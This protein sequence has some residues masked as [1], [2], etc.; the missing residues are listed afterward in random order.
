MKQAE[1]VARRISSQW[2]PAAI[3]TSPLS[4]AM[5]TAEIIGKKFHL[6]PIWTG[7]L[8][9][10]D[11]GQWQGLTPA[12][13]REKWPE[14]VVNWYEHPEV[15]KIPGGETLMDVRN[16]AMSALK[17]ACWLHPDQEIVLVSHTVV[18]RLILLGVLGL[19]IERFWH[20][21]QDPCAMNIIEKIDDDF[22][23]IS[24]NDV[25]HIH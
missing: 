11:Y 7:E 8:S 6:S 15:A 10:I 18:N 5:Q 24:M 4:R 12:E 2:K 17:E 9:D 22:V 1:Q 13:A 23:L 14:L 3:V 20:L 19:G 21:R 16:R 25:C